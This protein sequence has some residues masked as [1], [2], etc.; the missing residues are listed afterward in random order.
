MPFDTASKNLFLQLTVP[1]PRYVCIIS[2][3]PKGNIRLAKF[4]LARLN[5]RGNRFLICESRVK[6]RF[7]T[8][9]LCPWYGATQ[10]GEADL[11]YPWPTNSCSHFNEA[12]TLC[13]ITSIQSCYSLACNAWPTSRSFGFQ[14]HNRLKQRSFRPPVRTGAWPFPTRS[15]LKQGFAQK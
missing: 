3:A 12:S 7:V 6:I 4:C 13:I 10:C 8:P 15:D 9:N 5:A 2:T 11:R 1:V 14:T